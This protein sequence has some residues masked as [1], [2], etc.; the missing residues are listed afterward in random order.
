MS[1][2]SQKKHVPDALVLS[3]GGSRS[4]Y[5]VGVLK[6]LTEH[7]F[8]ADMRFTVIC[9]SSIGAVNSILYSHGIQHGMDRGVAALEELWRERTYQNTFEG[10]LSLSFFRSIKIGLIQYLSP[11]PNP[12]DESIFNPSPLINRIDEIISK[13]DKEALAPNAPSVQTVGVMTT[14]EGAERS[15]LFIVESDTKLPAEM[16]LGAGFD[17]YYVDKLNAKHA[18]ASAA[19]PSVLPPVELSLDDKDVRL[20]DGGICD[21]LPVDPSI[22]FGSRHVAV[23]DSSGRKWWCDHYG[24]SHDQADPWNITFSNGN[25]CLLPPKSTEFINKKAFGDVLQEVIGS[26]TKDY[27]RALGPIWPIYKLLVH[28]LGKVAANEIMSYA[29]LHEEYISALIDI[30]YQEAC[31]IIKSELVPSSTEESA[32]TLVGAEAPAEAV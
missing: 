12:T 28:R 16:T 3:G 13:V 4:A 26:S 20:V 2:L 19:L 18:F 6:A 24:Q 14:V 22:R 32:E 1:P 27:I 25:F 21:Y 29:V 5:Q 11:G 17:V 7:V 31:E 30:G 15:A 9:G 23:I 10:S 8:P